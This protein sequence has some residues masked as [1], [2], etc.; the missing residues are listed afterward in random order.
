VTV[1][2]KAASAATVRTALRVRLSVHGKQVATKATTLAPK[3]R[4]AKFVLTTKKP[5]KKGKYALSVSIAQPNV[6]ATAQKSTLKL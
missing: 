2:C 5:L 3:A 4:N 1:S 6:A